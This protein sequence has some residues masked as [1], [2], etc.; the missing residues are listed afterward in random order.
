[1][2]FN[3]TEFSTFLRMQ[4]VC[5]LFMSQIEFSFV[6]VLILWVKELGDVEN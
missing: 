4:P 1:M 6:L 2:S 5:M 3:I